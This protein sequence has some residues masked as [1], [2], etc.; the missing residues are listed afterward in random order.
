MAAASCVNERMNVTHL[1][2]F[3]SFNTHSEHLSAASHDRFVKETVTGARSLSHATG[4]TFESK[5]RADVQSE[6][7]VCF[8]ATSHHYDVKIMI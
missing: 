6:D 8:Y 5:R 7:Q 3:G 2:C 1:W 4:D